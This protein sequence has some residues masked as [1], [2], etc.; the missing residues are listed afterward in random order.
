MT[1]NVAL[2]SLKSATIS[3]DEGSAYWTVSLEISNVGEFALFAPEDTFTINLYGE[4]F[5][6]YVDSAS[7]N[8]DGP[9]QVSGTIKGLGLGA[10]RDFPRSA[11]L[12]KTWETATARSIVEELLGAGRIDDWGITDWDVPVNKF[13]VS[14]G[15]RLEA[16]KTL[17][18]VVGGLIEGTPEGNFVVRYRHPVAP[19]KYADASPDQV[20]DE[21]DSLV[22]INFD[23]TV[24]RYL[25]QVRVADVSEDDY[26]DEVE[27]IMDEDQMGAL[28]RVYPHPWRTAIDLVTTADTSIFKI[29]KV[30]AE[31]VFRQEKEIIEI[32]KGVG[33]LK[34]PVESLDDVKWKILPLQRLY[35]EDYSTKVYSGNVEEYSLAEITYTTKSI[36]FRVTS[37]AIDIA[38]FLVESPLKDAENGQ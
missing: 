31:P 14:D 24:S 15:S 35:P 11:N 12:T 38:Q 2:K 1:T 16:A 13:A 18:A 3:M 37:T 7:L 10:D 5:V 17:V 34:Y 21:Q 27:T 26:A 25:D 20:F 23:Y 32:I 36:D 8:K 28:V 29:D 4:E 33:T 19:W 22:S 30:S 6:F 9:G